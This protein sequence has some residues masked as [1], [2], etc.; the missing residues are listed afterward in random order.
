[1]T[2]MLTNI[3][4]PGLFVHMPKCAGTSLRHLL[5]QSYS[6]SMMTDYESAFKIPLPE[7]GAYINRYLAAPINVPKTNFVYGH[8]FPLKYIGAPHHKHAF[9]LVTILRDPLTRLIS[10][11][12]YWQTRKFPQQ[13]IWRKMNAQNWTFEDFALCPE[14]QNIYSQ[15]CTHIAPERFSYIGLYETLD[16]SI[17]ACM[18]HL[19]L[20]LPKTPLPKHNITATPE[21]ADTLSVT[22]L[23]PDLV[24]R[25][26][27][28]HSLDY[29]LYNY[30][31]RT[32]HR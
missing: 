17:N 27:K 10:N 22:D 15:I 14:F 29:E 18:T 1:M 16:V 12:K 7:R 20:E 32:F 31:I 9:T 3:S 23:D 26:K 19:G 2:G 21:A 13:Y 11:Y 30:A 6:D 25:I 28:Y 5:A 24:D 8:F 4:R